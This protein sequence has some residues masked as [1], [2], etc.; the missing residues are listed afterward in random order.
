MKG[1]KVDCFLGKQDRCKN[2]FFGCMQHLR[3]FLSLWYNTMAEPSY[4]RNYWA[5]D[6][7]SLKSII[8]EQRN[9]G[10]TCWKPTTWSSS[11]RLRE[12]SRFG[13]PFKASKPTPL[14][15]LFLQDHIPN[16]SQTVLS[17]ENTIFKHMNLWNFLLQLSTHRFT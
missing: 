12:H 11:R 9:G 6:L 1:I 7:R 10:R 8:A 5:Y 14:V 17:T 3:C 2:K 15:N 16:P 13:K 4:K